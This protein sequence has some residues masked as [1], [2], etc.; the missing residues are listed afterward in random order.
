MGKIAFVFSGQGAQYSG[1][2]KEL[3]EVSAGAHELYEKAEKLRPGTAEQS[4]SGTAEEL[5]KT[6]NTQPCLYLVDLA[7]AIALTEHGIKPDA[8][9]GFSLG[10]LAALGF[11]GA[12]SHEDGFSVTVRRGVLMQE[13]S[14][15]YDTAMAAVMKVDADTVSAVCGELENVYPVNFNSAAQTVVAGLRSELVKFKEKMSEYPCRIVDLP[16]SGGFHSPFMRGAAE[17]FAEEL[18]KYSLKKPDIPV[19]ANS[20]ALPYDENVADMLVK[21]IYSPV[22]WRVTVENMIADGVDT[23]IE[24]GAG[25]TLSGL[26]KKI[27]GDVRV[28]SVQDRATLEK[29]VEGVHGNA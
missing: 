7:A 8:V 14:D 11:A 26:I 21:Q 15:E 29:T 10:E 22:L 18:K 2:G 9:A 25:K 12:Y 23:F 13:A 4:F 20:T 5:K 24:V 19:Y 27:S 17:K 6:E 16:V 1:M 28:F 3:Y